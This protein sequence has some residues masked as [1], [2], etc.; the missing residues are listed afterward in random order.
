[1]PRKKKRDVARSDEDKAKKREL[2]LDATLRL[3]SDKG[4]AKTTMSDVAAEAKIG[5]G[6]VYWHFESKQELVLALMVREFGRLEEMFL[7]AAEIPGNAAERLESMIRGTMQMLWQA[8]EWF[9]PFL[10][11]I[12]S[13]GEELDLKLVE[14]WSALYGK[15]NRLVETMLEEAKADGDVRSDLD[16]AVVAPAIVGLLD[17]LFIQAM[18]GHLPRDTE[19]LGNSIFSLLGDGYRAREKG[20]PS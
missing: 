16:S 17:A 12:A 7:A 14:L 2:I 8:G 5:R 20:Q 1:M 4:Y 19:R 11:V 6:T 10:S 18:F 13:G 9:K 3:I 15:Y